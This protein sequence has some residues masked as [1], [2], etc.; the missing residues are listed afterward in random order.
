MT[1]YSSTR[2]YLAQL[3]R[4]K[5]AVAALRAARLFSMRAA[6]GPDQRNPATAFV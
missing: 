5:V 2:G 6:G 4:G 1:A 3:R